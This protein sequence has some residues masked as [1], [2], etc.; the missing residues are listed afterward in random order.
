MVES[1]PRAPVQKMV[2]R[3]LL[4]IYIA[5]AVVSVHI[6]SYGLLRQKDL[7]KTKYYLILSWRAAMLKQPQTN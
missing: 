4:Y 7:K 6:L 1:A 3:I 5:M 2:V